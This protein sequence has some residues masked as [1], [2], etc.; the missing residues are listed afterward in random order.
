MNQSKLPTKQITLYATV[1]F[2]FGALL[3]VLAKFSDTIPSNGV[4]GLFFSYISEIT[5]NLGIWVAL[6]T[7]LAVWS[8]RPLYASLNVLTF[9]LGMLIAYYVYSKALFGFFPTYYFVRWMLIALASPLAAYIVWFGKGKGWIAAF[10]AALP[11]GVLVVQGFPFFY[12]FSIVYALDLLLAIVLLVQL[13]KPKAQ[14][15]KVVS[16]SILV[17]LIVRNSN[18]LTYL[19]GGL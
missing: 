14:Y 10:C 6:A 1:C 16:L 19:F 5:T 13:A 9:F 15:V 8:R 7:L 4:T 18:L 11:I 3:G 2:L 17:F 12:V